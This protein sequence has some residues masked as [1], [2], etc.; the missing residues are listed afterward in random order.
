LPDRAKPF[1]VKRAYRTR[2]Q[3]TKTDVV[4]CNRP[5]SMAG[6][7]SSAAATI[8]SIWRHVHGQTLVEYTLILAFVSIVAVALLTGIGMRVQDLLQG[9]LDG[10]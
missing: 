6:G 10:F 7:E 9:V 4:V 1:I 8:R 2:R 3:F 5:K